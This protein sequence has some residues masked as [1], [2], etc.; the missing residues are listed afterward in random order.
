ME[1]D[2]CPECE[3]TAGWIMTFADLMSLLMCFFVLLLS[4]SEMDVLKYK[5]VAGSMKFAFG[6]QREI[7][8]DEIPKGTSVIAREFSPG[9]PQPTPIPEVRQITTDE[10]K[11]NLDFT[12]S[13]TKNDQSK[14]ES[15]SIEEL[16]EQLKEKAKE[17]AQEIKKALKKEIGEGVVELLIKED[18]VI[19]RIREK[20]SFKSGSA[21]LQKEF[22]PV[23]RRVSRAL[24]TI[25]G[26]ILVSGHTDNIPIKTTQFPSNWV[27]SAARAANVV[28]FMTS[29]GGVSKR[30]VEI[31]AHAD[32]SPIV[33]NKTSA[34]RAKNRRVEIVV[35]GDE[36]IAEQIRAKAA[37]S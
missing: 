11:Q 5:Q 27:L 21:T 29:Q 24:N 19:I 3:A 6:V 10:F 30:R 22:Y 17:K 23:M 2:E 25:K 20:G 33:N 1:E 7:K 4:F 9:K 14:S 28:H 31:R 37:K 16:Q 34:N 36:K 18:E 35:Q 15:N 8:A 12:D 13:D 32:M 26:K